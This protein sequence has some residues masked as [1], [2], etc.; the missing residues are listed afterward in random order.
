MEKWEEKAGLWNDKTAKK[1][2]V[3][4]GKKGRMKEGE[5]RKN[6]GQQR[7]G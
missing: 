1:G 2:R 6:R 3:T 5:H 4:Q 7:S